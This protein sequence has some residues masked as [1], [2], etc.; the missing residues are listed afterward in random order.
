MEYT[1]SKSCSLT[2]GS[3]LFAHRKNCLHTL[4][5]ADG[6]GEVEQ[7]KCGKRGVFL[8]QIFEFF[9]N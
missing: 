8:N 9:L 4:F 6:G 1:F 3:L 5:L 7:L 2:L